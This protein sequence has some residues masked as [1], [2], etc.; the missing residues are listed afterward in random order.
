[1]GVGSNHAE[2]GS[3]LCCQIQAGWLGWKQLE[4]QRLACWEQKA[5][6]HSSEQGEAGRDQMWQRAD[7]ASGLL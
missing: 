2:L 6:R 3:G 5:P 7:K 1:M 4:A